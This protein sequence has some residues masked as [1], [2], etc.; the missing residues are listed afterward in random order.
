MEA[1]FL[2][3]VA[4]GIAEIGDKTQ[5]LAILLAARFKQPRPIILGILAATLLNH[6]VAAALGEWL[7]RS[8]SPDLMRP[9]VGCAFLAAALWALIPDKMGEN[10][11]PNARY[12]VFF[13]ALIAFFIV[14]NGDKTQL[15]TV[16]LAAKY[17]ALLPVVIGTT[18][19]MMLANIPAVLLGHKITHI[20]PLKLIR[21]IAAALFAV[22]GIATLLY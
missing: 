3:T 22:L 21:I 7:S 1:L 19:G 16:M 18:L 11:A 2:S 17:Q 14:E 5:L 15:A 8:L 20:L 12:G 4:V 13:T 10:S 9:I 6:A